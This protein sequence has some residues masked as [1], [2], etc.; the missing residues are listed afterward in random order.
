[1]SEQTKMNQ[2]QVSQFLFFMKAG[3]FAH[4][5]ILLEKIERD[6][7]RDTELVRAEKANKEHLL[8][9]QA[10]QLKIADKMIADRVYSQLLNK[11]TFDYCQ[12][13]L[14]N[15]KNKMKAATQISVLEKAL[16]DLNK[17]KL[18]EREKII[19]DILSYDPSQ[20]EWAAKFKERVNKLLQISTEVMQPTVNPVAIAREAPPAPNPNKTQP[21]RR[22]VK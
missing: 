9:M 3:D 6:R 10:E 14:A 4:A 21:R 2:G 19:A 11:N 1:M 13:L 7:N 20:N 17:P 8:R 18:M 15:D 12:S 5:Q 16:V 22:P